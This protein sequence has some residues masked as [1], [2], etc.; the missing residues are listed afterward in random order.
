MPQ[1]IEE[2]VMETVAVEKVRTK[3]EYVPVER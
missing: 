1:A 3:V 2:T